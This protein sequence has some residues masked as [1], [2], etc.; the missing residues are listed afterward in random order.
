MQQIIEVEHCGNDHL[1]PIYSICE[2]PVCGFTKPR[3]GGLWTS[4]IDSE[5]S[6]RK[7][8]LR[9]DFR[10][11]QLEKSF[12]LK[13]DTSQLLIIDSLDDLIQKMVHP[14]IMQMDKYG[15]SCINWGQLVH[16]YNGIWLTTRGMMET[17]CSYP[18]SL[19][20]WDCETV[21]LFNKKPII[22]VLINRNEE[23]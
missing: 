10:V 20:G 16:M 7:W 19:Y 23:K 11:W 13:I 9:E 8:C 15:L 1:E 17:Y 18:Y 4:P 3:N 22:E 6:W 14:H 2:I 12:R 21:F 5:Y